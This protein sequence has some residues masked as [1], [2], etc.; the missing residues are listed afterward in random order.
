MGLETMKQTT[1]QT[2]EAAASSA[3]LLN[4]IDA[5]S[6]PK[7]WRSLN[8]LANA[9]EVDELVHREFP[10]RAGELLDPVS[11]RNFLRVM[12]A[13]MLLA[14]LGGTGCARQPQ[15]KILPYVK[16]PEWHL[17]GT[18]QYYASAAPMPG[19]YGLGVLVTTHDGRPTHLSGLESHKSSL[20][21]MDAQVQASLLDLYD[22]DRLD[23][24]MENGNI[25]TWG[26]F[27]ERMSRTM[28]EYDSE[29]GDGIRVLT[30][31]ITS[32]TLSWQLEKLRALYPALQWHQFE[33]IG[34]DNVREGSKM[35]FGRYMQTSYNLAEARVIV[36]LDSR[37]LDEGP[38]HIRYS[39]DF[40]A[41]R[42]VDAHEDWMSRLY[43]AETAP[44][45]TGAQADHK[46]TLRFPDIETLARKIAD[47]VGIDEVDI[48]RAAATRVE[49]TFLQAV[50]HDLEECHGHGV[51]IAGEEQP[52]V[53]HALAHAINLH[54][55]AVEAGVVSYTDPVETEPVNQMKSLLSL[56][57]D[58]NAGKVKCLVIL[59]GNPVYNTPA[60]VDFPAALEQL[61][62]RVH[63]TGNTNETSWYCNWQIPQI[64]RASCRERV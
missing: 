38:G 27:V 45:L 17:P 13:S 15:E 21:A 41:S 55:G 19:G 61:D 14:G 63:L 46:E 1:Q 53:V 20:G 57:E 52:P 24:V 28:N 11:R 40:A 32:P 44:S 33:S 9:Q 29:S 56:V 42:D 64:G 34:L 54:I 59:G 60:D 58:M 23:V 4:R 8:E 62:M 5:E 51:V 36:S 10:S 31:G 6:G 25:S 37:F 43:V 50:I 47:Q 49:N 7:Y 2:G 48:D 12:G 39:R 16:P 3:E 26:R 30:E 35:A 22:P 18:P